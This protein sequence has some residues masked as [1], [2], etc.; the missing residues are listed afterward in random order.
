MDRR[1]INASTSLSIGFKVP[2]R[3]GHLYVCNPSDRFCVVLIRHVSSVDAPVL[4]AIFSFV[5][6]LLF[7]I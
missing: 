6:V 1:I 4:V 5:R 2:F 7:R 3:R